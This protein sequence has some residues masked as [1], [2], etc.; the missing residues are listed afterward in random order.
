MDQAYLFNQLQVGNG[1]TVP[2]SASN[3]TSTIDYRTAAG[4]TREKLLTTVIPTYLCPSANGDNNNKYARY[5]GT[6]MYAMNNQIALVPTISNGVNALKG[7]PLQDIKD[8]TS[9]TILLGEKAL[10]SA[11]FDAIGAMW[12]ASRCSNGRITI[13]AAQNVM[14][15][16]FKGFWDTTVNEYNENGDPTVTR[17]VAASPHM[18]GC[19]FLL[20]DGTV[21]FISENVQANPTAWLSTPAPVGGGNY[22]YQNLYN[23]NDKNPMGEF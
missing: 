20:C 4:N 10:M 7:M 17:A 12:G 19:H 3:M 13:V 16:P 22:V 8:G 1:G 2:R 6:M 5:L 14:N 21:R 18:G 9:N 11:P 23:V 15:A